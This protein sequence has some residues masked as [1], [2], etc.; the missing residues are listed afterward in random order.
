MQLIPDVVM[1][2][3]VVIQSVCST[4]Q[5]IYASEAWKKKR[6]RHPASEV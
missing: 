4:A 5:I 1:S 3:T 2:F 6:L